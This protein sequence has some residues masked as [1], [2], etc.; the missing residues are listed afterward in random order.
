MYALEKKG[1]AE[2]NIS[3][4][5]TFILGFVSSYESKPNYFHSFFYYKVR[6]NDIVISFQLI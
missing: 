2:N 6:I 5:I 1:K 3:L 4:F